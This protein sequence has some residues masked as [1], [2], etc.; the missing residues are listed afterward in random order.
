MDGEEAF[1]LHNFTR[2]IFES[3]DHFPLRIREQPHFSLVALS[4]DF[5]FS[6]HQ[7]I[8]ILSARCIY[9]H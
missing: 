9:K 6:Y 1:L 8:F 2:F 3:H 5:F 7:Q 4:S